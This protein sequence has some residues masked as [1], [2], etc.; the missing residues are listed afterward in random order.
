[1]HGEAGR[2][3]WEGEI[4]LNLAREQGCDGFFGGPI[5]DLH[6]WTQEEG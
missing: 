1:M 6:E 2:L 5:G 3:E 4:N